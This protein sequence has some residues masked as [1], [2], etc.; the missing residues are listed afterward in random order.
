M[1]HL[2]LLWKICIL[3]MSIV[4]AGGES[5]GGGSANRGGNKLARRAR[6]FKEDF[7][8]IL[9]QMRSPGSGG[10][11]SGSASSAGSPKPPRSPKPR[12]SSSSDVPQNEERNPLADL[13]LHVKQV[14]SGL[15]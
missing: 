14:L 13:D 11:T 7:L 15:N 4:F 6:S 2:N 1:N 12:T 3:V 9:S 8:D 10:G 5:S